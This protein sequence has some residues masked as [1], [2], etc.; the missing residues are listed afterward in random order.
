MKVVQELGIVVFIAVLVGVIVWLA[1]RDPSVD[2]SK[3]P[4]TF[5]PSVEATEEALDEA[6]VTKDVGQP[7]P[8]SFWSENAAAIGAGA[9][10][11]V[12]AILLIARAYNKR[13]A[14]GEWW[15]KR[16][17]TVVSDPSVAET[18]FE[19]LVTTLKKTQ[20]KKKILNLKKLESKWKLKARQ[21]VEGAETELLIIRGK[22]QA[23][24]AEKARREASVEPR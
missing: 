15:N 21:G 8:T 1:T 14:I 24:E 11:L 3:A 13:T 20:L 4:T 19:Q 18:E 10:A 12:F 7:Q 9:G 23:H 6:D 22:L 2:T 17:N 16:Q 5:Q